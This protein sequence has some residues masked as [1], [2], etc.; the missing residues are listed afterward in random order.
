MAVTQTDTTR[1]LSGNRGAKKLNYAYYVAEILHDDTNDPTINVIENT[2]GFTPAWTRAAVGE[3]KA[4]YTGGFPLADTVVFLSK[5]SDGNQNGND[6]IYFENNGT[7]EIRFF[8]YR[9][10]VATD[11]IINN[12]R[13]EIRI[14]NQ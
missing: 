3:V 5:V 14:Y 6:D 7:N 9:N 10:A 12:N 8:Q 11:N 4:T 1:S 13:V 2:L